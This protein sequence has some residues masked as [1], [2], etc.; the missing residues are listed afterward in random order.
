MPFSLEQMRRQ[1]RNAGVTAALGRPPIAY[2]EGCCVG[3]GTEINSG[4]YRR[5][6]PEVLAR[7][8]DRATRSP[9]SPTTTLYDICDEVE[10]ALTCRPLPGA[11]IP[12]S[13][14]LPR[15]R[16]APRLGARRDPAVD[17][18]RRR[19]RR[20]GPT[21]EHDR[22][23]PPACDGGRRPPAGRSPRR[24]GS[25]ADGSRATTARAARRRRHG[26][27]RSASATSSCAAG[28]SRRRRCC[29]APDGATTS[30]ARSPSIRR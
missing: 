25:S 27:A 15:R 5:P 30:G 28:R 22:D 20:V 4:L 6:P 10:A 11:P 2:T 24:R 12:A 1:Y 8:R 26:A 23:V 16:G 17:A 14:R 3:G 29:S 7:W 9:T 21:P 19:R 18:L 13:A